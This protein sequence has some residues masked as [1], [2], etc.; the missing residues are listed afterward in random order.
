MQ[1]LSW[2]VLLV[3]V[4]GV[5]KAGSP[6]GLT[7]WRTP[8]GIFLSWSASGMG[9]GTRVGVWRGTEPGS[10]AMLAMLP[11]GQS[12]FLDLGSQKN[13]GYAYAL[14]DDSKPGPAI[15]I[16]ASG[17]TS[18][19]PSLVTTCSGLFKGQY[20]A[21]ARNY[22]RTDKDSHVQFFGWYI[23]RPLVSESRQ[24]RIVWRDSMG[25][26]FSELAQDVVP[27]RVDMQKREP[28]GR[29]VVAQ[30]IGLKEAF[31]QNGQLRV[32][33]EPGLYSIEVTV[34]GV[35]VSLT[36]FF[37]LP[38]SSPSNSRPSPV[39]TPPASDDR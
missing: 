7:G 12:G 20:P 11:A 22:F 17:K 14:G 9:A 19:F 4:A 8:Q 2:P 30:A 29:I 16:P 26:V 5:A 21:D 6:S 28:V 10:L 23:V 32:P 1:R 3:L 24:V 37:I 15:V 13:Q 34:D 31:P 38:S 25:E 36:I 39:N 33:S 35:Q 27:Q 18:L